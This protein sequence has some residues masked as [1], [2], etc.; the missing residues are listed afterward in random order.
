MAQSKRQEELEFEVERLKNE[1]RRLQSELTTERAKYRE[2]AESGY[3]RATKPM[4]V[5][6]HKIKMLCFRFR[7]SRHI[8]RGISILAKHG[9][10]E[11][12][13]ACRTHFNITTNTDYSKILPSVREYEENFGFERKITF[14]ILLP[15]FN[16]PVSYLKD[17]I[18]SVQA[19]TYKNWE[20]CLVDG[21][22]E[23]HSSTSSAAE[24]FSREDSRIRYQKVQ[25]AGIS[26]NTN[27]ALKMSCGEYIALFDHDDILHPSAL[28]EAMQVIC[29]E[30][31]DFIYTDEATF[32]GNNIKRI[33]NFHFKPDFAPDTLRSVNYIC[34]FSLF[35]RELFEKTGFFRK[36][37]DGSQDH[38]MILR[39][40]ENAAV[41]RH[42]N[43]L[44]YFWRSHGDSVSKNLAVKS[45]AV[46]AGKQAVAEA[47]KR[48]GIPAKLSSSK[49]FPTMYR[50]E[51]DIA[52]YPL[53]SI[54]IP[55]KDHVADL[56]QCIDSILSKTTYPNYEIIVIE[57]NSETSEIFNYYKWAEQSD[58]IKV[59]KYEGDFNYSAI[60]NFGAD[61]A[62]GEYLLLLNNDTS[63]I[64][65]NWIE[66]MM[67]Y[68]QRA[69]VGIVGAK[70]Y[71]PDNTIQHAGV[72]VGL[73]SVAGHTHCRHSGDDPGYMGLGF[74]VRNVSAVTGACLMIRKELFDAVGG[75]D[76]GL[77]VAFN[78]IDL[79]LKVRQKGY[80]VVFT[81][82][83][84]LYHYES[85][86]RGY[87]DTPEKQR[88]F[89]REAEF[90]KSRW[91][92]SI[93]K[94]G[95]PYYNSNFSLDADYHICYDKINAEK[96]KMLKK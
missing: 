70:L 24:R 91:G 87:E 75:L 73:G 13:S 27:V 66:E 88:R 64:S 25:N 95:D 28:F 16:T 20:L 45:Y 18:H 92:N 37:F 85:K 69:D 38:D 19:Q 4:R 57:N 22:D 15:V 67:M 80:L 44:L 7:I 50:L 54:L 33:V 81:P 29:K 72:I 96:R 83:A 2:I 11:L 36:E 41:I 82:Y 31:A 74:Y 23:K 60:N 46:D 39:L 1:N 47:T 3:W 21:S 93:L 68:A 90:F 9:V 76:C 79:C 12:I 14:S 94:Q 84:E 17:A 59:V 34:H 71:Y 43:K 26:E 42:I 77:A 5:V 35:S 6:T 56:K 63:I 52:K 51:Y 32:C 62:Q 58:K 86:S 10:K 8:C 89:S 49:A 48:M 65:E 53:V 61:Y 78:D 40:T 30:N 55:N